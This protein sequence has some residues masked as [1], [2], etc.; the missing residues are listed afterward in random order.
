MERA[1]HVFELYEVG[2]YI[3][4]RRGRSFIYDFL[5]CIWLV[6]YLFGGRHIIFTMVVSELDRLLCFG[7]Y[8]DVKSYVQQNPQSIRE[9]CPERG[10]LPV[11]RI[12]SDP[13]LW[14][15]D[16]EWQVSFPPENH[17]RI[18]H[19]QE[20]LALLM[21]LY[22]G[23]LT[24]QD[25][26]N[27]QVPLHAAVV[28]GRDEDD[29]EAMELL[30]SVFRACPAASQVR[31][32]RGCTPLEIAIRKR[33]FDQAH[34][35]LQNHWGAIAAVHKGNMPILE[36]ALQYYAPT[37]FLRLL[38][39]KVDRC[40]QVKDSFGDLP[41]HTSI[42][43]GM[44]YEVVEMIM[45]AYP[46]ALKVVDSENMLPLSLELKREARYDVVRLLAEEYPKAASRTT[47]KGLLPIHYAVENRNVTTEIL[48]FLKDQYPNGLT[49]VLPNGDTV[50][51]H[52]L[53]ERSTS[54]VAVNWLVKNW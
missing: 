38:I 50:L 33:N 22:P 10:T 52:A 5:F 16:E 37:D 34:Y 36:A 24:V 13:Q 43:N 45:K 15:R 29:D 48:E 44:P 41:L 2:A 4:F 51:H 42:D 47:H 26:K 40:A 19:R 32:L 23:G 27:G 9:P 54:E 30:A 11:H 1:R 31:D 7:S 20:K 6:I 8:E 3:S 17:H 49:A 12:F 35:L 53:G 14:Y 28:D 21:E 39:C 46:R 25:A 18:L